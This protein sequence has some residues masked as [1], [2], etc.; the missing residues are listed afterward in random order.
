VSQQQLE[1]DVTENLGCAIMKAYTHVKISKHIDVV[2]IH[3]KTTMICRRSQDVLGN[4]LLAKDTSEVGPQGIV[5][6]KWL[7]NCPL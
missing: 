3:R 6:V 7:S 5:T 1:G 2:I 4:M